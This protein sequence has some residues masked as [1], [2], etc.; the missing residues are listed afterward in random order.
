MGSARIRRRQRA[1]QYSTSAA[2]AP[3][4]SK[5]TAS[6]GDSSAHREP[7][8]LYLLCC[9]AVAGRV[10]S[11][12]CCR[13][14]IKRKHMLRQSCSHV[15]R[16]HHGWLARVR[17]CKES[18]PPPPPPGG[19]RLSAAVDWGA[20]VCM[21]TSRFASGPWDNFNVSACGKTFNHGACNITGNTCSVQTVE[22]WSPVRGCEIGDCYQGCAFQLGCGST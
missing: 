15:P 16:Q 3:V 20:C 6:Q 21:H 9:A 4:A 18:S 14:P 10:R 8:L 22:D 5:A 17:C 19:L 12:I 1:V 11:L 2:A 13:I 7:P